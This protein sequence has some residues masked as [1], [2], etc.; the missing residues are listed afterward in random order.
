LIYSKLQK[1]FAAI[2]VTA[3]GITAYFVNFSIQQ[4]IMIHKRNIE[5]RNK[6]SNLQCAYSAYS[7]VGSQYSS[8]ETLITVNEGNRKM[9]TFFALYSTCNNT[10]EIK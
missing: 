6:I 3:F 1:G 7:Y 5:H 2:S 10:M 9:A 8:G 4:G